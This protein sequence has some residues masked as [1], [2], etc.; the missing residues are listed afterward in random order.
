LNF[1]KLKLSYKI[2]GIITILFNVIYYI[3]IGTNIGIFDIAILFASLYYLKIIKNNYL[4]NKE[5]KIN[6]LKK[7]NKRI[8]ILICIIL[9]LI[10]IIYFSNTIGDRNLGKSWMASGYNIGGV[11]L[12]SDSVFFKIIPS[13]LYTLLVTLSAY[14]TQ[15]YYGLSLSMNYDWKFT[16]GLGS[17]P[18]L[19]PYV[20]QY[21]PQIYENTYQARIEDNYNWGSQENWHSLYSWLAN[22]LSF[23]GVIFF[24][25]GFGYLTA[26][27][28]KDSLYSNNP[29]AKVM[30]YFLTISIFFIPA[31]NQMG[32]SL[33]K[34]FTFATIFIFWL[35]G[36]RDVNKT[37]LKSYG[38]TK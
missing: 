4:K 13:G 7:N 18:R 15:G 32:A 36:R 23:I 21:F 19:L 14:L 35:Y 6:N 30:F 26:I 16:F 37:G 8:G 38:K 12:N 1:K 31:N 11:V 28:Y 22:D 17:F 3:S 24:M 27:V 29:F 33:E 25:F 34:L 9:I 20:E 2:I 5:L 10:I